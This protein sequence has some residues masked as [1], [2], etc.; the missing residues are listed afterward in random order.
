MICALTRVE[1]PKHFR[2]TS[3]TT[4][5]AFVLTSILY[6]ILGFVYGRGNVDVYFT[7]SILDT[8]QNTFRLDWIAFLPIV[9]LLV[10]LLFR[11]PAVPSILIGALSGV[12]IAVLHQGCAPQEAFQALYRGY[13]SVT[14]NSFIDTLLSR[15]GMISMIDIVYLLLF[16]FGIGGILNKTGILNTALSVFS[17][18]TKTSASLLTTTGLVAVLSNMLGGSMGF[19]HV[20]TCTLMPPLY[21]KSDLKMENLSR[22]TVDIST[23]SAC[24]IPWNSNV[25]FP[26]TILGVAGVAFI[27]FCFFHWINILI[28]LLF[29]LTG[30]TITKKEPSLLPKTPLD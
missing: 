15:G 26:S 28:S 3:Y 29:G 20:M 27:P 24:L 2:H 12:L 30:F 21:E 17:R 4:I 18:F 10:L 6:L 1:I 11:K 9:I 23:L 13:V 7:Q 19:A 14:G 5:P 22:Q 25:V 8:F 16:G